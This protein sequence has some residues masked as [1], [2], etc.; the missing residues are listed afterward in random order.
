M[1]IQFIVCVCFFLFS[2]PM[3]MSNGDGYIA[4]SFEGRNIYSDYQVSQ[5]SG[6]PIKFSCHQC[7]SAFNR[8]KNLTY[9]LRHECF[10][11]PRY[12]CP[13]CDYLAKQVS[14]ARSHVRRKHP[15]QRLYT[16]DRLMIISRD[17]WKIYFHFITQSFNNCT[18]SIT[19]PRN[20][21]LQRKIFFF[22]C[23]SFTFFQDS[24]TLL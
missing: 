9:H 13:Y 22:F 6:Q 14:N 23:Y 15:E 3:K 7:P 21:K 11:A 4:S 19:I 8:L 16:V 18:V 20:N 10:Q 24:S 1:K 2:G 17:S 5:S 12:G